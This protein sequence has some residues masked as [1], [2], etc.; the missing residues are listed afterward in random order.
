MLEIKAEWKSH[1][2]QITKYLQLIANQTQT[3]INDEK[4]E[5]I[6]IECQSRV[7]QIFSYFTELKHPIKEY[8]NFTTSTLRES[9]DFSS[10]EISILLYKELI[11]NSKEIIQCIHNK[12]YNS[13]SNKYIQQI[14]QLIGYPLK[15]I[16]TYQL[17]LSESDFY[18]PSGSFRPLLDSLS[19]QKYLIKSTPCFDLIEK[20]KSTIE[21]RISLQIGCLL[22]DNDLPSWNFNN[23]EINQ[24]RKQVIIPIKN[25]ISSNNY[26]SHYSS[27]GSKKYI[28]PAKINKNLSSSKFQTNKNELNSL[29]PQS[30][31]IRVHLSE[32]V[33]KSI[34]VNPEMFINDLLIIIIK[35]SKT[36]LPN[37]VTE[38][39]YY[40]QF[41]EFEQIIYE[42]VQLFQIEH[43]VFCL[44]R[45]KPI[46]FLL[47]DKKN[48]KIPSNDYNT[49][50]SSIL[51]INVF[52]DNNFIST[53]Q[54]SESEYPIPSTNPLFV[55]L[56]NQ[57]LDPN[58]NYSIFIEGIKNFD[59]N[60]FFNDQNNENSSLNSSSNSIS[61]S[62]SSTNDNNLVSRTS[63]RSSSSSFLGFS[64]NNSFVNGLYAFV[65]IEIYHNGELLCN[66]VQ[67]SF[68][69]LSLLE[70]NEKI[71]FNLPVRHI[72]LE[73]RLCFTLYSIHPKS[74]QVQSLLWVSCRIYDCNH[75]LRIEK[76]MSLPMF[77]E[78]NQ[79]EENNKQKPTEILCGDPQ[80]DKNQI[81][82]QLLFN[83]HNFNN[84]SSKKQSNSN[85]SPRSSSYFQ[86]FLQLPRILPRRSPLVLPGDILDPTEEQIQCLQSIIKKDCLYKPT[87]KEK[88]LLWHC[89]E[90]YKDNFSGLCKFLL[91]VNWC[92]FHFVEETYRLLDIWKEPKNPIEVL[93]LLSPYY[94]D[95]RVRQYAI[96]HLSLLSDDELSNYL[97]Q[98]VQ[99][100][101]YE[102]DHKSS[103]SLFLLQRSIQS[104]D[105]I[106]KSL[107]WLLISEL[108]ENK[109]VL[110]VR[111]GLI[112]E[113]LLHS[114]GNFYRENLLRQ[115]EF[116]QIIHLI[117][118]SVSEEKN[119]NLKHETLLR[120]LQHTNL[121]DSFYIPYD[122]TLKVSNLRINECKALDSNRS[123]LFLSFDNACLYKY[124]IQVLF[125]LGDDLR[126]DILTLQLIK[127]MDQLWSNENLDLQISSYHCIST[128]SPSHGLI[129]IVKNSK[130]TA[131]IHKK[132]AG[133]RGA[134]V[135]QSIANWLEEQ[136]PCKFSL[137][138]FQKK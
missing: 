66:P 88:L 12:Y 65:K 39:H 116:I 134:F 5:K 113:A 95:E 115:K 63:L 87:K 27:N 135:E 101:K 132:I 51:S 105:I 23:N 99:V 19:L 100:L 7:D 50:L 52:D 43:I 120:L 49:K 38:N 102:K 96:S 76:S 14:I 109:F 107:Y 15:E 84:L 98:L 126:Q 42:N 129:E 29:L 11:E 85:Q 40:L 37:N 1:L 91:S 133:I 56:F 123:P 22:D 21:K 138:S 83:F 92:S 41:A 58:T 67:S 77:K 62:L 64:N 124:P 16:K 44:S 17:K 8:E 125:K 118:S 137:Y 57:I 69:S 81:I 61:T 75:C 103:T 93:D 26:F 82:P 136:N 53:A 111:F 36:F 30:F 73:S 13:N 20:E 106:G 117:S 31:V 47:I 114:I 131:D 33:T 60:T 71:E 70:W 32:D 97:I 104:P 78:I 79:Q 34:F 130:T 89:R 2:I 45:L 25:F 55:P 18:F 3:N 48:I 35:K 127:I 6:I 59:F 10:R 80:N 121:P 46:E 4:V 86:G 74:D 72:P 9:Q 119:K 112:L 54:I 94:E 28:K 68:C 122:C 24:F 128:G 108:N 110:R 90:F